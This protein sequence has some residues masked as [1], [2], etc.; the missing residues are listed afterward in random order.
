MRPLDPHALDLHGA[1]L[2]SIDAE[3]DHH[4]LRVRLEVVLEGQAPGTRSHCIVAFDEVSSHT[5]TIDW[6]ELE[7]HASEGN[8]TSW[9][10]ADGAGTTVFHLAHGFLS[11]TAG[12]VDVLVDA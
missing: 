12:R 3:P 11:V 7:R 2:H 8:V 9:S 10:P 4:R 5:E 6:T 1:V